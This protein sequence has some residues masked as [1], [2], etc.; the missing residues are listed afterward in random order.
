MT[1]NIWKVALALVCLSGAPTADAEF[2]D[3]RIDL[4]NGNLLE[5]DEIANKTLVTFGLAVAADGT[6]SRVAAD[7]A[8][9]AVVISGKY[10]SNEHGWGNFS[11]TV[12]VDGPVKVSM[13][14]CAWGGDVTIKNAA[15]E[16]VGSF[17]TNTGAC[18]HV[19]KNNNIAS[20]VYKGGAGTLTVSGGSYTPYFAVEAVDPSELV[21]DATVTFGLGDTGA[22]ATLLPGA[23]TVAVG[24]TVTIPKNMT[25]Y[26][27]GKTL[28]G[29]TDGTNTYNVGE[30]VT[31]NG[32][33]ELT[34]V[35]TENTVTLA[36]RTET[37]T[38]RWDF[39]RQNGAPSTGGIQGKD[40]QVWVTQATIGGQTIDVAL[41]FSTNPGK[42]ANANWND[43]AQLN[44]GTTF[45]VPSCKGAVVS[46]ESFSAT[47]TT[48]IDGQV[49]NQGTKTPS[50]TCGTATDPVEV[51]I[52]DGSYFRY[53]QVELPV[54]Q[55][56]GG[57]TY[58]NEPASVV[59]AFNSDNYMEDVTATPAAGFSMKTFDIGDCSFKGLATTTVCGPDIK[60][61]RVNSTNGGSDVV[62]WSVKPVKGVIF[63]PTSISFYIARNG[64]DGTENAVTVKANVTGGDYVV[65]GSITP[66]R[67]NKT[68]A[69]DKFGKSASYTTKYEYTLTDEQRQA[70]TSGEGFNLVLNNGYGPT[71][72]C[73]YSDVQI[74]G[75]LNGTA[76]A[77]EMYTLAVSA[78]PAEGGSV[79]VYPNIAEY[80]AGTEVKLTA[81][82]NFGYSFVNWTDAS[83][84]VVS[85]APEF[86][87]TLTANAEFVAH[88]TSLNTYELTL[89]VT[90]G[91]NDYQ[92]QP[93]PAG[94]MVEGKRMYEEGT[95][96][97]LTAISNPIVA[98]ASWD[99]GQTSSEIKV[100]MDADKAF[101]ANFD[102]V[103]YIVGWDFMQPGNNGRVA[104]FCAADN[105]AAALVLRN[106]AGDVQG[107]LDKSQFGAGGYEG[108]PAAVNW[109]TTGIGE[110]YWQTKVNAEA[111][112]DIKVITAMTLNYN[113]YS[114]QNVEYSLDGENWTNVGAIT[115]PGAKNWTDA[116]FSLPA[117]ANNQKD[118][119]IRWISDKTSEK[120]GTTS[121]NDGIALGASFIVGTAKLINDGVAP[122]L[123]SQVPE[124]GTNTASINGK[125]V[126]TFDEKV[127]VK[128]DTKATLGNLELTPSVTGKTVMFEYKN[129]TYGTDYKFT[130]AAG[131]VT[132]LTDN[133]MTEPIVINFTTKTRPVVAKAL[134]DVTV[135]TVDELVDAINE[136]NTRADKTKRFR[137]FIHDGEYKLPASADKTKTGTDNVVYPDPTTYI[138]APN[139][140]FIGESRDGVVI[141]NTV[142]GN[143][144]A[145]E[146]EA[147]A[148]PLEGIGKGDVLRL[149]KTATNCYFQNLTIKSSMGDK[150]GRDIE[151]N[152]NSDK[153]IWKDVCLWGYQDTYVSNNENGRFYFEGGLLRG[154]TDF[155]CGKGDVYYNA[156]TLRMVGS[157]Y[158]AVPSKPKKYG[159]IFKDCE[160]VGENDKADGNKN[161]DGAYKLGR[162]W[163]QGTPIAL[164]IDTK[165]TV[166]PAADGWNEMS[167]GWPARFA[168]YNSTT[169]SGTVIDLKDRKTTYTDKQGGKHTNNPVLTKA[170]ADLHTL[171][172][173]MGGDD[174]WDPASI[175]EQAPAPSNVVIDN[176]VITWDGSDYASL[177]A[178]CADGKVIGFTTEPSYTTETRA[179]VVYSVRAANE[180][181][182][183][184]E[185][186][187]A[188]AQTTGIITVGEEAANTEAVYY[189]L[190]GIR[191]NNPGAGVYIRLQNGVSTK[192]V[193]N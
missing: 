127:K 50:F 37:V 26:S 125:I 8:S 95:I 76:E 44:P 110:Y 29:W 62:T 19:D 35:F 81:T 28:T 188:S 36:D 161:P 101:T 24:G 94:T 118:L 33:L 90:G 5:S 23:Q 30:T 82:N 2:K 136:A 134:Y 191:V 7:D 156:V 56:A 22:L 115:I 144:V 70:L 43:W 180:M 65:F 119:Y 171:A 148:N 51:V 13:G 146:H 40:N 18:F 173:V 41:P 1:R 21:E 140:S 15:G 167:G 169:A 176:G 27:E 91:A 25:V 92:V 9:S 123:V 71:K 181:G 60:F 38:L 143:N 34:P 174:D 149:E 177:W 155:L 121:N 96:V 12:S 175:A 178:V 185:S 187:V 164:F 162:P 16:I 105:D 48:T 73:M 14:T 86:T 111:F 32:N 54:A 93:T 193:L 158:L 75:V 163:G 102:A 53:I 45:Q 124:E 189:N 87:H 168:E 154:R 172:A 114:K 83:G 106:A 59:W 17:N 64:T 42:F 78:D 147:S 120:I 117:A 142:P 63:A 186:V 49:I 151:V 77:V 6:V 126:L 108:R 85:E 39:Q 55:S 116:T 57:A 103:D 150:K 141:T 112:S 192:V 88:F 104:D 107:W 89:G 84:A 69:D 80:E 159:Y 122:V 67:N 133:A 137:I 160:I 184:G 10:H 52:G 99:D 170:E 138:T 97:T 132:D 109:R 74:H 131:S 190:Q 152:D 68:Q 31:V 130:L 153:T 157:G 61:V 165:M 58:T 145:G 11:S 3:I 47:T 79:S 183:L 128:E 20:T 66:H 135:S 72:D 139:I 179:E 46:L 4:T 113:A 182:G 166:R 129:L 98:F 100:T